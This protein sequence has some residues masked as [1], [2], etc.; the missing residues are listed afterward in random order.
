MNPLS[1]FKI[2]LLGLWSS[3]STVLADSAFLIVWLVC[4]Y[5]I[6]VLIRKLN[7]SANIDLW[8]LTAFR[9]FFAFSTL[10]PVVINIYVDIR[11]LLIRAK[12]MI[13]QEKQEQDEI[14]GDHNDNK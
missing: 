10:A 13:E 6:D 14:R 8:M 5:G 7:L 4:Q 2:K 9:Y 11:I 3:V 12:R 1:W